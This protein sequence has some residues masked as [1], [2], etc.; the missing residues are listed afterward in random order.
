[1]RTDEDWLQLAVD[2]AIRN[3]ADRGG[4]FGAVVVMDGVAVG[5]GRNRVTQALDPTAHAEIVA[6]REACRG[7]EDFWLEGAIL[8]SSCEPC[9]M[10]LAACLWARVT[11]VVFCADRYAAAAAGFD[12]AL[13]DQL[14]AVT[15]GTWPLLI[16]HVPLPTAGAPFDAWM[17]DADRIPY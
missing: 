2:H 16:E 12:D 7:I 10:C 9:P 8:Y 1:M 5:A 11:R 3:V 14:I 17:A 15:K 13:F 6:L 4:P